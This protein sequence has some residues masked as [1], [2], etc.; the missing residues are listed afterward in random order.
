MCV[1]GS[2]PDEGVS[3]C[4]SPKLRCGSYESFRGRNA[5]CHGRRSTAERWWWVWRRCQV[6]DR[7]CSRINFRRE[8]STRRC[9]RFR[10]EAGRP[11]PTFG[12]R[13]RRSCARRGSGSHWPWRTEERLVYIGQVFLD[14]STFDSSYRVVILLLNIRI[15]QSSYQT[16]IHPSKYCT[17]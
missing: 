2:F 16:C 14:K 10:C 15:K 9:L 12:G 1:S 11:R 13:R 5:S 6:P 3:G 4:P 7:G 8:G 17:T